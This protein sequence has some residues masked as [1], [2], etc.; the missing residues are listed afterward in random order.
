[1]PDRAPS[2]APSF[3][4]QKIFLFPARSL[5]PNPLT[6]HPQQRRPNLSLKS[7]LIPITPIHHRPTTT[8]HCK[9]NLATK[10]HPR[11][12]KKVRFRNNPLQFCRIGTIGGHISA[13]SRREAA[14]HN[15]D[16]GV[17]T[18]SGVVNVGLSGEIL[19]AGRVRESYQ[20]WSRF[21]LDDLIFLVQMVT[22]FRL[23]RSLCFSK[24]SLLSLRY[25]SRI[26]Y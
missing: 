4:Q 23:H 11:P 17:L 2:N 15:E 9:R 16:C 1:M 25:R 3:T 6:T 14:V 5:A 26:R 20:F 22:A 10:R 13:V 18:G 8:P 19:E 24:A 7:A 21:C 12:G